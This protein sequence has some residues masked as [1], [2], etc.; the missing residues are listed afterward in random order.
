M[1]TEDKNFGAI[2]NSGDHF[3]AETP[4]GIEREYEFIGF[5]PFEK[6]GCAYLVI[7]NVTNGGVWGVEHLWFREDVCGRK[8]TTINRAKELPEIR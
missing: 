6:T 5:A 1:L 4:D 7:R 3:L 2:L 8:I